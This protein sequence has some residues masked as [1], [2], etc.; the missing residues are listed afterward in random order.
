MNGKLVVGG[1]MGQ[2]PTTTGMYAPNNRDPRNVGNYTLL[3]TD[4]MGMDMSANRALAVVSGLGM[5]C[6][7]AAAGSTTYRIQ[8][9]YANRIN[10]ICCAGGYAARDEAT[11]A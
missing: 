3:M 1:R 4:A 8:N 9:T 7:S 5:P 2:F 11:S 10:A 6:R